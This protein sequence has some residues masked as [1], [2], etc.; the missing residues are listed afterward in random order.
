M[1]QAAATL[2]LKLTSL[3]VT[4]PADFDAAFKEAA[5]RTGG[6]AVLS[7]PLIFAHREPVV[8]AAA[9][10]KVPAI[11]YDAEYAQSNGLVAYGPN[12]RWT[13]GLTA[14]DWFHWLRFLRRC[15]DCQTI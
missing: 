1:K 6:V 11:Y 5:A 7:G 13:H 2:N 10:Y 14:I 8:A 9:R 4:R 15:A 12:S 3:E